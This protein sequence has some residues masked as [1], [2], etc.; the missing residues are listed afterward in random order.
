MPP[1]ELH[2]EAASVAAF[3]TRNYMPDVTATTNRTHRA[4]LVAEAVVSA[5]INELTA[6]P[7][8]GDG[9]RPAP[10]EFRGRH[11]VIVANLAHHARRHTRREHAGRQITGHDC[12]GADYRIAADRHA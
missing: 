2:T 12:A 7:S 6:S 4:Q 10:S 5:Y 9:T 11:P 3:Q 1:T 8:P